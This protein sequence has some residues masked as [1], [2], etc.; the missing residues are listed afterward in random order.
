MWIKFANLCRNSGRYNLAHK[1]LINLYGQDPTKGGKDIWIRHPDVTYSYLKYMWSAG[2]RK[3]AVSQLETFSGLL[4]TEI[5]AGENQES[6]VR[7]TLL[8]RCY[9]KL[10]E[11]RRHLGDDA[12]V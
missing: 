2:D 10:A 6:R 5:N 1:T 8:A 12:S 11:W 4:L 7:P 3:Q 9:L